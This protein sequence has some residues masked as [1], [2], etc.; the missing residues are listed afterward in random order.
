MTAPWAPAGDRQLRFGIAGLGTMGR[1]HLRVVAARSDCRLA[2]VADPAVEALVRPLP[3]GRV[4]RASRSRS[5]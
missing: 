5:R 2:A 4:P 3:T 1:N